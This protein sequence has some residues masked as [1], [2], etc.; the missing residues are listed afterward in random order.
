ML[1]FFFTNYEFYY[2]LKIFLWEKIPFFLLIKNLKFNLAYRWV[3]FQVK[4]F[5]IYQF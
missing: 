2:S 3:L 4:I 1:R 5:F